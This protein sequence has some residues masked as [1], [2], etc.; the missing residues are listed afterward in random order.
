MGLLLSLPVADAALWHFAVGRME[1]GFEAW[2]GRAKA[3]GWTIERGRTV[4]GGWPWAATLSI[5][6]MA[7]GGGGS[8][9]PGGVATRLPRVV[10]RIPMLRPHAMDI[11]AFGAPHLR[12]GTQPEIELTGARL[13]AVI[14]L[15]P[16]TEPR[17]LE[18]VADRPRLAGAGD[19]VLSATLVDVRVQLPP[20]V[21]IGAAQSNFSFS[22]E[23]VALPTTIQWPLGAAVRQFSF[24]GALEGPLPPAQSP[25]AWAMA[26]RDGGGSLQIQNMALNWGPLSLAG[27]ATLALD[28]QLQPM[29]AGTSKVTGYAQTLDALAASGALS[30]SA[31]I[32]AKAVLSLLAGSADDGDPSDVDVPLTLQYRTLSMRQVPLLRLPEFDW[33]E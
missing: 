11:E 6:D 29:G 8:L 10:L 13:L 3:A 16:D 28:D 27:A 20:I 17:E 26:W 15:V 7:I 9:L 14:R 4:A 31:A 33:P 12:L 2:V 19:W 24:D 21:R 25:S 23:A 1:A 30:R 22:A 5:R 18:V 32:A